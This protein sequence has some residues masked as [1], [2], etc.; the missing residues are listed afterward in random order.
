MY[1]GE[2]QL[3]QDIA[4]NT[5]AYRLGFAAVRQGILNEGAERIPTQ[6]GKTDEIWFGTANVGGVIDIPVYLRMAGPRQLMAE[7]ICSVTAP[8]MGLPV[9]LPFLVTVPRKKLPRSKLWKKGQQHAVCFASQAIDNS[10]TFA[11]LLQQDS[12]YAKR[13]ILAW[14][15]YPD[16][17]VFDEWLAN[18]DRNYS[19]MLFRTNV[20]WL[21]DHADAFGGAVGELY[22]LADLTKTPFSNQLLDDFKSDFTPQKR[23]EFLKIAREML[24]I[25]KDLD[26]SAMLDI[27]GHEHISVDGG[28]QEMLNFLHTRLDHTLPLLCQRLGIPELPLTPTPPMRQTL[29]PSPQP[30]PRAGGR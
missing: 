2:N 21:I 18:V 1:R 19:N 30:E 4:A 17:A 14:Q 6:A 24:A 8:A 7:L 3:R 26:L 23:H 9:P 16:A 10:G 29:R 15:Q 13:L 5:G 28:A 20:I 27:V 25:I 22:P 11:Q 12:P